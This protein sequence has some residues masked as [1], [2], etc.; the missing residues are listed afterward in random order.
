MENTKL[1]CD[2]LQILIAGQKRVRRRQCV[3]GGVALAIET[4][5]FS[6]KSSV[7]AMNAFRFFRDAERCRANAAP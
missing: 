3:F 6:S 7:V 4:A 2:A 1:Q 5:D